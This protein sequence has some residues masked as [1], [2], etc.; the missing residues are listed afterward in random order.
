MNDWVNVRWFGWMDGVKKK[1]NDGGMDVRE[2]KERAR[3][4]KEWQAIV[5]HPDG[6]GYPFSLTTGVTGDTADERKLEEGREWAV[7]HSSPCSHQDKKPH[8]V[9]FGVGYPL[10]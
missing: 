9:L 2:A 8:L 10:N 3:N 6:Y 7:Y 5:N 1:L 4:R